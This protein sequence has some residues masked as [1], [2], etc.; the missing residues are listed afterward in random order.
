MGARPDFKK[1]HTRPQLHPITAV[2]LVRVGGT[3]FFPPFLND[4][5]MWLLFLAFSVSKKNFLVENKESELQG[6]RDAIAAFR[7]DLQSQ[8]HIKSDALQQAHSTQPIH[9]PLAALNHSSL[10]S[11]NPFKSLAEN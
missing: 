5:K 1:L 8:T 9:S 3:V 10:A 11:H 7:H 6:T 4:T 2:A